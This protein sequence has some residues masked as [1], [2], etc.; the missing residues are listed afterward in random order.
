MEEVIIAAVYKRE[1]LWNQSN[2]HHK[3]V[4]VLKK[5]W[6]EVAEEVNIDDKIVRMKWKN[7]RTYFFREIRKMEDP[8]SGD[9]GR[10][11]SASTWKFFEQMMFMKDSVAKLQRDTN[12]DMESITSDCNELSGSPEIIYLRETAVQSSN[13]THTTKKIK[14]SHD[15]H[16]ELAQL[17]KK[18]QSLEKESLQEQDED[19][20]FF[21]SLIPY[22][23]KIP[24]RKKLKLRSII[25]DAILEHIP[26]DSN[27]DWDSEARSIC[28][29]EMP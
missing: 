28:K 25:Q 14:T 6:E 7:L 3:N 15:H 16:D 23:K 24:L 27:E 26:W 20:L 11:Y 29:Q 18:I 8:K 4:I 22:M 2:K 19:L 10:I 1:P 17:E 21:K 5:L 13:M 9:G 12:F